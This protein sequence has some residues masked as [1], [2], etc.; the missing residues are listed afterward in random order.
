VTLDQVHAAARGLQRG[1]EFVA[2]QP[3]RS[4]CRDTCP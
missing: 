4:N 2:C 3:D 1:R